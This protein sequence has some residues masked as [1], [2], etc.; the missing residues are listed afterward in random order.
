MEAFYKYKST[1]GVHDP[2]LIYHEPNE[3]YYLF[4][5]DTKYEG[6]MTQGIPIRKSKDLVN[7]EYLGTALKEIPKWVYKYTHPGNLWAP[8]VVLVEGVYNMYY[9][10]SKFGTNESCIG[11][12][13]ASHPEGP[14]VDKGYVFSSHP[15]KSESN[16]IDAN[17]LKDRNGKQWFVYGSFF[18]GIYIKEIDEKTGKLVD[19]KTEGHCIAR[20]T[21]NVEGAIEG[22]YIYYHKDF[23]MYYLFTSYDF[24]GASY[25]IRVARAKDIQG[26][27]TDMNG[28]KMFGQSEN[29]HINGTKILGSYQYDLHWT[30]IGH[31]SIL[32]LKDKQYLVAHSRVNNL[33][34]PHYLYIKE[35]IWLDSGW[36]TVALGKVIRYV[37]YEFNEIEGIVFDNLSTETRIPQLIEGIRESKTYECELE[38]GEVCMCISGVDKWGRVFWGYERR[39]QEI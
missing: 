1:K 19:P 13:Q 25:N 32:D 20:R 11:L 15:K 22:P 14:W 26:P 29:P 18:S 8:E 17:V 37:D 7:W 31:N 10:A 16:A 36:P 9:S 3:T 24:L 30:S 28:L 2:T 21:L 35:I 5:T 23:D 34:Y 38:K 6:E 27:Y 12:A 39:K 33:P 4:S